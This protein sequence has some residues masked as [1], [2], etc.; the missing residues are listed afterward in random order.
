MKQDTNT[1]RYFLFNVSCYLFTTWGQA[2]QSRAGFVWMVRQVY[3]Q[4][5]FCATGLC[6]KVVHYTQSTHV[7]FPGFFPAL[8]F[9]FTAVKR[10][11]SLVYTG[12]ITVTTIFIYK[13]IIYILSEFFKTLVLFDIQQLGNKRRIEG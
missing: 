5:V 13:N 1:I 3:A 4:C 10:Q 6:K 11:F 7:V 12:L 8:A 9:I 2:V